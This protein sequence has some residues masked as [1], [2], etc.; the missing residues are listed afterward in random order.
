MPLEYIVAAILGVALTVY[1][2]TG[3]A[4]FGGGVWDLLATGPRASRQRGVI[5]RAIA[6]IW[7]ANHVWLILAVVLMFVSFPRAFAALGTVLHIP[8]T[9]ALIGIVLRGS[10]FTFR[11]YGM[12][13]AAGQRRWSRIFAVSSLL[14]PF[15]LGTCVGAIA[16]GRIQMDAATGLVVPDFIGPWLAPFPIAVGVFTVVIFAYIA[17]VYLTLETTD[18]ELQEDFRRRGLLAGIALAPLA[19]L[20]WSL[21]GDTGS[22][23]PGLMHD[24]PAL[25]YQ[26]VTAIL[27][28][29]ALV[30]LWQRRY[31]LARI[32]AVAQIIAILWGWM[33]EQA[34]TLIAPDLTFT[35]AAAPDN[36]LRNL[37]IVLA[38]GSVVLLPSFW[39]LYHLFKTDPDAH[40]DADH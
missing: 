15:A 38:I 8:L 31:S 30:A 40:A 7:E 20:T 22:V 28:V 11:S 18:R 4:D 21:A 5:E 26:V 9:L 12:D 14:T 2:L 1:S 25:I 17:A 19:W 33:L 6:P 34:P 16:S 29:A 39:W 37:L 32:L 35:V 23:P 24:T 36:I 3:G 13:D 27:A 10:A